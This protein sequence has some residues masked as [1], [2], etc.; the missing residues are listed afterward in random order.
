MR[1]DKVSYV[2]YL[3]R[4]SSNSVNGNTDYTEIALDIMNATMF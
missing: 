1:M 3:I 4:M 2:S